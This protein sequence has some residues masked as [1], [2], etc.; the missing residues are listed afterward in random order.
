MFLAF[1]SWNPIGLVYN[2]NSRD[3]DGCEWK[4]HAPVQR[5][6]MLE[7]SGVLS[8]FLNATKQNYFVNI[9]FS[10]PACRDVC[11]RTYLQ[12]HI[13]SAIIA[14]SVNKLSLCNLFDGGRLI[15]RLPFVYLQ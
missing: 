1:S 4:T 7:V 14:S 10:S 6:E 8:K 3:R 12:V 5:I 2:V 11:M 15:W 9:R 13:N